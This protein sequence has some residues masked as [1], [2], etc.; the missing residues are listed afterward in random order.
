MDCQSSFSQSVQK[1]MKGTPGDDGI[2]GLKAVS[3][4]LTDSWLTLYNDLERV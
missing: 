2:E 3:G 1:A 4:S